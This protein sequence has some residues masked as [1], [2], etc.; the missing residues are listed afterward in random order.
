MLGWLEFRT[1]YTT[2]NYNYGGSVP[3]GLGGRLLDIG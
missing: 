2:N 1:T 3:Q